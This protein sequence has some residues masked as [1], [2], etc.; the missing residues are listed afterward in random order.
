ML[1]E[2]SY[3]DSNGNATLRAS[4]FPFY[5]VFAT[6]G[7]RALHDA[8]MSILQNDCQFLK[9]ERMWKHLQLYLSITMV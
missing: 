7:E 1:N 9:R 5:P 3:N 2:A 8:Q 4:G 6:L